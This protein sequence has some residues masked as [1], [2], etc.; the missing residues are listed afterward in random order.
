MLVAC[1]PTE[2]KVEVHEC[3]VPPEGRAVAMSFALDS[4]V[5]V[6]SGRNANGKYVEN[7]LVYSARTDS[8]QTKDLPE[9]FSERGNGVACTNGQAAYMGLGFKGGDIYEAGKYLRDFWRYEPKTDRW[10]R[11]ADFPSEKTAAAIAFADEESVWVGFG[12]KGYGDEW[13]RYSIADDRWEAVSKT[14]SWPSRLMSMAAA[15]CEGRFFA[16]TGFHTDCR[17][18]WWEFVPS[19]NGWERRASLPRKGRQNA[20]C[21]ATSQCVWIVGGWHNGD[22]LT[23]GFHFQDILCY[24]PE[25]DSWQTCGVIPCGP[26]EN[27]VACGIG[28]LLYFGLGEND[29][30]QLHQHWYYI[31]E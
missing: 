21:G 26:T 29:M 31:E 1:R 8:W 25:S 9:S 13:W 23:T 12:F 28:R 30:Q 20:A 18:E 5:Y 24:Q 15:S 16:G 4:T 27:G 7:M 22:P 14:G 6:V 10:T 2:V 17:T 11:L 3:A 19:A